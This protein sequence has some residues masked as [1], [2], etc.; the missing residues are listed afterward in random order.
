MP[1]PRI[2]VGCFMLE[3]N[4]HS[5]L[6]TREEFSSNYIAAGDQM[7]ADWEGEHPCCPATLSGFIERMTATGAWA[8]VPLYGAMVGASGPVEHGFFLEVLQQLESRLRAALP[9]DAVF[10]SLHGG[11][12][13]EKEG[14]PEGVVL[15]RVRAIVGKA[16]PV[17]ATLDLHANVSDRMVRNCDVLVAYRTNPHIDMADRGSESADL[18]RELLAGTRATAAMVKLPFIPPS[19]AQNTKS[20]PYADIIAYGQSKIDPRVMN[21]SV[22]SGFSL[23][24]CAKNGMS[25]TVTT[26]N[27]ATLAAELAK[28]IAQKCWDDRK[29]YIPRLTT[30][31]DATRMALDCGVN[32]SRPAL[33][34]A[35]VADN[36]GGGGRGN[37]VWIL[38]SFYKAGVQGALLGI[39]FDPALVAEAK[40]LGPGTSFHAKFNR[41]E[42]HALSGKFEADAQV[43]ALH[44][45]PIVGKRGIS[46]GHS[47]NLGDMALVQ[48]GGIR[49]V[50]VSVRQQ[51]KDIA[52]FECFGIDIGAARS[53]IVKSRG[54]FRAAFDI[55]FTDDC[56][57]EVDVPGLTTPILTRV[58]YRNVVRPIYPLD[59]EMEWTA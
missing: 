7:R 17:V 25:I 19:V 4:G 33:L 40:R 47:I 23:G 58:P 10:L 11:A 34:F 8:P 15:E 31:A 38:E 21:V 32:A 20:G 53:V 48:V 57:I 39:V 16:I 44:Q 3:S 9:V 1:N 13:G 30:L 18:L 42:T 12:I 6:A 24:D 14:D 28:D 45:G 36:P 54:H 2:A 35:D 37:T 50:L 29:R 59:A 26:R 5:P 46:A 22:V 27:D 55:F 56:I 49:V 41:D 51:C 43:L 52:M